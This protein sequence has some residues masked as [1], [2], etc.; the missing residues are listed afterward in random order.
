VAPLGLL[1]VL[2]L[3]LAA[4]WMQE[5]HVPLGAGPSELLLLGCVLAMWR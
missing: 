3:G 4:A 5:V 2:V 1:L